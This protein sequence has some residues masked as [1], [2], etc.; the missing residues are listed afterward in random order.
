MVLRFI[1]HCTDVKELHDRLILCLAM[2]PNFWRAMGIMK[3]IFGEECAITLNEFV[4]F[5]L[6]TISVRQVNLYL[7]MHYFGIPKSI[8]ST[9]ACMILIKKFRWSGLKLDIIEIIDKVLWNN[10]CWLLYVMLFLLQ[11]PSD[12]IL[13]QSSVDSTS[14]D[15]NKSPHQWRID[16]EKTEKYWTGEFVLTLRFCIV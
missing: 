7:R 1:P 16:L 10:G 6:Q 14:S 12:N 15:D 5:Y 8:Q 3:G 11:S 2:V 9:E 13:M 4:L